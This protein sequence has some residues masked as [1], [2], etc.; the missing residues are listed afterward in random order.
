MNVNENLTKILAITLPRIPKYIYLVIFRRALSICLPTNQKLVMVRNSSDK[1]SYTRWKKS[2]VAI[3]HSAWNWNKPG[4]PE[5]FLG[6]LR[7]FLWSSSGNVQI[8]QGILLEYFRVFLENSS[9]NPF[10][11]LPKMSKGLF[12][13]YFWDSS[14]YPSRTFP[15]KFFQNILGIL[16]AILLGSF[17]KIFG[18]FFEYSYAILANLLDF[19]RKSCIYSSEYLSMILPCNPLG[20]VP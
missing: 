17:H 8:F 13:S 16:Q 6:F 14:G 15:L 5:I 19:F 10:G 9:Q 12:F 20:F 11:I 7:K 3:A 2:L 1:Q 4:F 18:D